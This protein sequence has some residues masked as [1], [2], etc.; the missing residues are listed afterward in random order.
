MQLVP[1]IDLSTADRLLTQYKYL[2]AG[3]KSSSTHKGKKNVIIDSIN[4][5]YNQTTN[6]IV[7]LLQS[8]NQGKKS[9]SY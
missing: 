4:S 5:S 2:C 3:C 9:T 8:N 1:K 7:S 6:N